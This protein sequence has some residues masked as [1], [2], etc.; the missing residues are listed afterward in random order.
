MNDVVC[1]CVCL[2]VG[3]E[4]EEGMSPHDG[5]PASAVASHARYRTVVG[6]VIW[7]VVVTMLLFTVIVALFVVCNNNRRSRF[8]VADR[9]IQGAAEKPR[10]IG[11]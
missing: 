5:S 3:F 4:G 8:R 9:Y 10:T 1:V 7:N 2:F 11:R 6:L